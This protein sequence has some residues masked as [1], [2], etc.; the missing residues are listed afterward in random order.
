[1]WRYERGSKNGNG[2]KSGVNF[3]GSSLDRCA[4][5]RQPPS[6]EPETP[7]TSI[8]TRLTPGSIR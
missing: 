4:T 6:W 7:P 8:S 3:V 5:N 2:W 1:M